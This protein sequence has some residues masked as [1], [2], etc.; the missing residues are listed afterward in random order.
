M[1]VDRASLVPY[2]GED[3]RPE[4]K[5]ERNASSTFS[6][7]NSAH[8]VAH[9]SRRFT[10]DGSVLRHKISDNDYL[11]FSDWTY[12]MNDETLSRT[13]DINPSIKYLNLD[14]CDNI[15]DDGLLHLSK[16]SNLNYLNLNRCIR[17]V[18]V[19]DRV[20]RLERLTHLDL[21]DI[22]ALTSSVSKDLR[23]LQNLRELRIRHNNL[24]EDDTLETISKLPNL[25]RLD[26]RDCTRITDIGMKHLSTMSNLTHLDIASCTKIGVQSLLHFKDGLR[27][28]VVGFST[29]GESLFPCVCHIETLQV[30]GGM[31]DPFEVSSDGEDEA[32]AEA[33]VTREFEAY[34]RLKARGV[35]IREWYREFF[36][37]LSPDKRAQE[38][39]LM[40]ETLGV[41]TDERDAL[42]VSNQQLWAMRKGQA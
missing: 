15:T 27:V 2:G 36:S 20:F 40:R 4:A 16:L 39:Q 22:P 7:A 26:V 41:W 17:I 1:S 23:L 13:V 32:I 42:Y 5:I 3:A 35:M 31:G 33:P 12:A 38:I 18:N 14:R 11:D 21:S 9:F 24:I 19:T 6:T 34:L 8:R 29:M 28:L 30:I 25:S 37:A 10:Y